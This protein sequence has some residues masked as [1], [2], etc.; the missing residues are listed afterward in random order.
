[1]YCNNKTLHKSARNAVE[2]CGVWDRSLAQGVAAR[3]AAAEA[4][5]ELAHEEL[6]AQLA[7]RVF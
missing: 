4:G 3:M 7:R 2:D 6:Q 1:M 5:L